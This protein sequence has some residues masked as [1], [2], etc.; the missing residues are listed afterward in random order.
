[1]I[2]KSRDITDTGTA[3]KCLTL[4]FLAVHALHPE[5]TLNVVKDAHSDAFLMLLI[6]SR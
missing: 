1:M 6:S 2:T 5:G 3:S 4:G